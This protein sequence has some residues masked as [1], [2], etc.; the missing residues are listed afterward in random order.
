MNM[1]ATR[2][3]RQTTTA[4]LFRLHTKYPKRSSE[5]QR[6]DARPCADVSCP[7]RARKNGVISGT[8]AEPTPACR[9]SSL[10][11]KSI[12]KE[13]RAQRDAYQMDRSDIWT[14]V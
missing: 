12:C 6:I 1:P 14:V 7:G 3:E 13:L 2:R 4:F 9:S 5:K 11:C 10:A 8:G